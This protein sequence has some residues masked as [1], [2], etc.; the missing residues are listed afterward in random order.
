MKV[1]SNLTSTSNFLSTLFDL[2]SVQLYITLHH[3]MDARSLLRAKKAESRI[4][5]PHAT[6]TGAGQLRCSICAIPGTSLC[7]LYSTQANVQL[8]NGTPTSLRNSTEHPLREKSN[9]KALR[10]QRDRPRI[11]VAVRRDQEQRKSSKVQFSPLD[12]SR[13]VG[14]Q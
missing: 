14:P 13:V 3:I 10:N 6:Y 11:L 1:D 5:H 7:L 9:R 12:S 4:E 8:N 2:V